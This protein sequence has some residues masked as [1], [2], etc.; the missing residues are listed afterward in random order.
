MLTDMGI[1]LHDLES[2]IDVKQSNMGIA[3]IM[4]EPPPPVYTQSPSIH[5]VSCLNGQIPPGPFNIDS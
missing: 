4:Q 3:S 5:K 1:L 2:F